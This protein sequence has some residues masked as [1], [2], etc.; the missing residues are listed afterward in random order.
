[1]LVFFNW[2]WFWGWNRDVK[3]DRNVGKN[4]D[5]NTNQNEIS[6]HEKSKRG[7]NDTTSNHYQLLNLNKWIPLGKVEDN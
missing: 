5:S 1:M 7:N 4:D 3:A 6:L 2:K